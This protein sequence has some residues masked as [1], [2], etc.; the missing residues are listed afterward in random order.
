D[1]TIS[2]ISRLAKQVNTALGIIPLGS[3]NGY[4]RHLKIPLKV[5]KAIE[6]VLSENYLDVDTA[7]I[8]GNY[9]INIA[10]LGFDALISEQF[11]K[12]K[13]RGILNYMTLTFKNLF[14]YKPAFY[15][16]KF[17]DIEWSGKAVVVDFA[18]GTQYG[19]DAV[20]SPHSD[21]SDGMLDICIL[22]PYPFWYNFV[23]LYR[24]YSKSIHRSKYYKSFKA[25]AIN[26]ES[27]E[28]N[29]A[30][31][32]GEGFEVNPRFTVQVS[33]EKLKVLVPNL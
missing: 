8:D 9:Y 20:I 10:G 31:Y 11:S 28:S 23:L 13:N 27:S 15:N 29:L 1:G 19:N 17:N 32:D 25:E 30:H 24:F 14:S 12:T 5:E 6:V 21:P 22:N 4:A 7:E 26:V 3:G 16:L 18:L 33:K 2:L